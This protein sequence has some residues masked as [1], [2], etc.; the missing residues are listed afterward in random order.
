MAQ[1]NLGRTAD[2]LVTFQRASRVDPTSVDAW[3]GIANAELTLRDLDAATAA[4]Q[5]AQ[6]LQPDRPAVRDTVRRLET[7]RAK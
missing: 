2:A 4:L 1:T 3:I 7:L 5:S 6:R